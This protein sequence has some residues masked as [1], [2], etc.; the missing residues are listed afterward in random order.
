MFQL[1]AIR[2]SGWRLHRGI[3]LTVGHAARVT[4]RPCYILLAVVIVSTC[5]SVKCTI[6]F[7]IFGFGLFGAFLRM[8]L[9]K[10]AVRWTRVWALVP[11]VYGQCMRE[12]ATTQ[13]F[14]ASNHRHNIV[15]TKTERS[16][17]KA[18]CSRLSTVAVS[19]VSWSCR[20]A[21]NAAIDVILTIVYIYPKSPKCYSPWLLIPK[22]WD[23]V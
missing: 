19:S 5:L 20:W 2:I 8:F 22:F 6:A 10:L 12:S 15:L 16:R 21:S 7:L 13:H 3:P 1:L 9:F 23:V 18:K 14:S 17:F 11:V 4:S